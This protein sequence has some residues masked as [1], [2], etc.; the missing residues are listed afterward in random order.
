MESK[1]TPEHQSEIDEVMAIMRCMTGSEITAYFD[2]SKRAEERGEPL[3][4]LPAIYRK[5]LEDKRAAQVRLSEMVQEKA[6][7]VTSQQPT[8]TP[9]QRAW[10]NEFAD[11]TGGDGVGLDDL[12]AGLTNFVF[13]AQHSLACYRQEAEE[14]ANRLER[15][16]ESLIQ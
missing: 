16:L 5:R 8:L 12:E 6:A 13:A 9:A 3:P 10:F 7:A 4:P 1:I 15:K 2:S 14:T 11:S